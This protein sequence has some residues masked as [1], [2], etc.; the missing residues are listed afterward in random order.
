MIFELF[1]AFIFLSLILIVVGY[2][3][4][5]KLL[6]LFGFATMFLLGLTINLSGLT[7]KTGET[8]E[9]NYMCTVCGTPA[10]T[11][12]ICTGTPS[13][14]TSFQDNTTCA[15]YGC[16]WDEVEGC[17]GVGTECD[18]FTDLTYCARSGCEVETITTANATLGINETVIASTEKT[19][20]YSALTDNATLWVGR[21]L[22]I[23]AMLGF[24]LVIV[25]NKK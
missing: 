14:C 8:T 6:A 25:S 5:I 23:V 16:T 9:Y 22:M 24:T 15:F 7:Y 1:I 20:D 21:W 11:T 12:T 18:Q 10:N 19:F 4:D 3:T 17:I 2:Y 13:N